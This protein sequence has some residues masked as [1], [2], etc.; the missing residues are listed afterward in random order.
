MPTLH[1]VIP[2]YNE[3]GT[4]E[5]CLERVLA[6]S[7]PDGWTCRIRVV[8]DHS[9]DEHFPAVERVHRR[10]A[11]AGHAI[12]LR[13][14]EVNRGK[15]AALQSGFD[16]I[17]ASG[18]PDDDL[19]IIQDADLEYD[20]NDYPVLMRPLLDGRADAVLGSRWGDHRELRGFK[21]RIH[22]WGNGALTALSN[23]MTGYRVRDME[24]CYKIVPLRV[25]RLLR[26]MLTEQRFGIEPQFVASLARLRA[27][28]EEVPIHYDPRG[29]DAGKKIGW[30]DGVRAI[31][32]IARERWRSRPPVRLSDPA[33]DAHA[34]KPTTSARP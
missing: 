21:R 4:L 14:H 18:A 27:R 13:R 34:A 26:P 30:T 29:L 2:V 12:S 17:L 8:D 11:D 28:V 10:L 19:A 3:R 1:V 32:V 33:H 15:G 31:W 16:E 24:C 20:P 25:L 23:V 22:A 7:L 9:D 5:Q 6:V